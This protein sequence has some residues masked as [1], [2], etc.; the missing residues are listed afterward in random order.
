[1]NLSLRGNKKCYWI[2]LPSIEKGYSRFL[3]KHLKFCIFKRNQRYVFFDTEIFFV[4]WGMCSL[5]QCILC[6][7][8]Y[9]FFTVK[10]SHLNNIYYICLTRQIVFYAHYDPR[11]YFEEIPSVPKTKKKFLHRDCRWSLFLLTL[12]EMKINLE[13]V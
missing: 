1:M 4:L 9:V 11:W 5:I 10:F 3:S 6:F 13:I 8:R 12:Y 7:L 2:F